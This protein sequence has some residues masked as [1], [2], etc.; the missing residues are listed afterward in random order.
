M[1]LHHVST[2]IYPHSRLL[3]I[4]IIQTKNKLCSYVSPFLYSMLNFDIGFIVHLIPTT[5]E[6]GFYRVSLIL[7]WT[8]FFVI[9]A[10]FS[11]HFHKRCVL[12]TVEHIRP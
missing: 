8:I 4:K 2:P 10:I 1:Y 7:D 6:G 5:R 9:C 11:I 12:L 3:C